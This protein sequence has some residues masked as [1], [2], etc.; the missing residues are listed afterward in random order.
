MGFKGSTG[1]APTFLFCGPEDHITN[2]LCSVKSTPLPLLFASLQMS[3]EKAV[4]LCHELKTPLIFSAFCWARCNAEDACC[5]WCQYLRHVSKFWSDSN[6]PGCFPPRSFTWMLAPICMPRFQSCKYG[7]SIRKFKTDFTR[8]GID[9]LLHIASC[10]RSI[11]PTFKVT[12][13]TNKEDLQS[14][15]VTISLLFKEKFT[16]KNLPSRTSTLLYKGIARESKKA[17]S[18]GPWLIG[19]CETCWR[20]IKKRNEKC[21]FL[22]H[23]PPATWS[24]QPAFNIHA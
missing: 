12:G 3:C 6:L 17:L 4:S 23:N 1:F 2:Y 20:S 19:S 15:H 8:V 24:E 9:C 14:K 21:N 7:L 22:V 16:K 11:E 13:Y 5:A 10:T 18:P